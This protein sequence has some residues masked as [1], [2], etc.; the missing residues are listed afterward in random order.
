MSEL[1]V[2]IAAGGFGA[3]QRRQDEP[4]RSIRAMTC[5]TDVGSTP[6][7]HFIVAGSVRKIAMPCRAEGQ[8]AS[9]LGSDWR[10]LLPQMTFRWS[11][12]VSADWSRACLALALR[13][14]QSRLR[15]R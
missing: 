5:V 2:K 13:A 1:L 3:R 7:R 11:S 14:G 12:Q 8:R 4:N 6:K 10:Y 15:G 9:S